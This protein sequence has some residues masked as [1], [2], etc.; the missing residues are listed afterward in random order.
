MKCYVFTL[1][2]FSSIG[3]ES[4]KLFATLVVYSISRLS[5]FDSFF[6]V[7]TPELQSIRPICILRSF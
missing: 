7:K 5:P 6:L 2:E 3:A 4:H 1:V